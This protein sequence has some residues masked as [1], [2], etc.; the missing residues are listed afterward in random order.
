MATVVRMSCSVYRALLLAY[1]REFRQ[2]FGDEMIATF[3]DQMRSERTRSGFS[4]AIQVWYS[5]VGELFSIA[6]PLQLRSSFVIAMAIAFLGSAA[7]FLTLL[8]S[9]TPQCSK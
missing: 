3:S 9:V 5:A 8:R 7:F 4:G 2:R 1:P 6:V